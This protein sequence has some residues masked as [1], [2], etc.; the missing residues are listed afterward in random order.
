MPHVRLQKILSTLAIRLA[1][2]CM[3]LPVSGGV[4]ETSKTRPHIFLTGKLL[5]AQPD[6][7][8]PRFREAVIFLA[9]HDKSGAFGLI[10]NRPIG[11]VAYST[12]AKNIGADPAGIKGKS[13][14]FYG[15]PVDPERGFIL[16]SND[17]P[18][19]PLIPVND[20]YSITISTDIILALANGSGPKNSIFAIG[21]AGWREGQL[22]QE[23]ERNNW[24]IAPTNENILF[25][26]KFESKWK[27]A[28]NL[29][30]INI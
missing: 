26:Q 6:M 23:I 19:S 5:V 11:E 9:R 27:R 2:A 13:T 12:I 21:Y 3:I 24:V 1:L 8:D 16:H 14:L 22:E 10:V 15:G 4:A 7:S 29:R 17:Y 25:D 18:H 20:R 28:Y 30:F